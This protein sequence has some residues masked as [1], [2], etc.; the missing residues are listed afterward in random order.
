MWRLFSTNLIN[1]PGNLVAGNTPFP[2][3]RS[4]CFK[5]RT[6]SRPIRVPIFLNCPGRYFLEN[7]IGVSGRNGII[8]NSSNVHLDLQGHSI[9]AET[10]DENAVGRCAIYVRRCCAHVT[11]QGGSIR[12]FK[13]GLSATSCDHLDVFG[14]SVTRSRRIG[15]N[16]G[17]LSCRVS[18]C[19]VS[20]IGGN[21]SEAYAVGINIACGADVVVEGNRISEIYRQEGCPPE[22]KG[23]GCAIILNSASQRCSVVGNVLTNEHSRSGTIGVFGGRAGHHS[24]RDNFVRGYEIALQGGG[25]AIGPCDAIGNSLWLPEPLPRSKGISIAYGV[26]RDNKVVGYE[27]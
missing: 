14:L 27:S 6:N 20:D 26:V 24:I 9:S 18:G 22:I 19:A 1:V 16:V 25:F 15:I 3:S 11:I 13:V 23:E 4:S 5:I 12:G 17:G 2:I 7:D 21:P 10:N 8:I